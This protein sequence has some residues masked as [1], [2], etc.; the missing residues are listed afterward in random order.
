M[1]LL[2]FLKRA[3]EVTFDNQNT[4]LTAKNV[5]DAID[6]ICDHLELVPSPL[7]SITVTNEARDSFTFTYYDSAKT[8]QTKTINIGASNTYEVYKATEMTATIRPTY[9]IET[10]NIDIISDVPIGNNTLYTMLAPAKGGTSGAIV[11]SP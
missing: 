9:N 2:N 6:Q 5:Q 1:S 10:T 11:V 4:T 8:K 7:C 3:K